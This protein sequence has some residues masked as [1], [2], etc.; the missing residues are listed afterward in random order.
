MLELELHRKL[1]ATPH[2]PTDLVW[3]LELCEAACPGGEE[4]VTAEVIELGQDRNHGVIGGLYRKVLEV[5]ARW[6]AEPRCSPPDFEPRL[7]D[8]KRVEPPNRLVAAQPDGAER[9]DPLP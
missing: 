1:A 4:A 7:A 2:A 3:R 5:A 6:V 8:E 9:L